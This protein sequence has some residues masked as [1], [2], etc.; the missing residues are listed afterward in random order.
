APLLISQVSAAE[1]QS[2]NFLT[3]T[4]NRVDMPVCFLIGVGVGIGIV[5]CLSIP[6]PIPTP[7]CNDRV[8]IYGKL[9]GIML[10][11]NSAS[12]SSLKNKE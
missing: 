6:V 1:I 10:F 7:K 11:Y 5:S 8:N 12:S 2:V 4:E 3:P 9:W